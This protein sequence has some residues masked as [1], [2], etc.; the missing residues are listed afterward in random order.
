MS[1]S[2]QHAQKHMLFPSGSGNASAFLETSGLT[3]ELI[4][5]FSQSKFVWAALIFLLLGL[6]RIF[7][8]GKQKLPPGVK[9]LPRLPG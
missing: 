6:A 3:P 1:Q 9:P 4:A 5:D 2:I 7:V 8:S